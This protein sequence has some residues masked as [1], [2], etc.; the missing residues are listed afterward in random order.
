[1]PQPI[2]FDHI[3]DRY[4]ATRSDF[5]PF[6]NAIAEGLI[7]LSGMP[8]HGTLLEIAIGTGRI[9]LPLLAM[10]INVTGV[11]ISERMVERL[12]AKYAE[13]RAAE[14]ARDWGVLTTVI[15]DVTRLPCEP[16]T[17]DAALAVH[18]FHLVHDWRTALDEA[19]RMVRPGGAFL[20]GQDTRPANDVQWQM[21][22]RWM[23][24]VREIGYDV[25]LTYPG[26]G[27]S[28]VV[29][30]LRERGLDVVEEV[31]ATWET[32]QTP[33][34]MTKWITDRLW[35]RTWGVPD[36]VFAESVRRLTIWTQ[37]RFRAEMDVPVPTSASFK[38]ARARLYA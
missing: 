27:Y 25:N 29:V 5:G 17:F 10:G 32:E 20:L 19:L 1:M 12:R 15:A 3:A 7:R 18:I 36:D 9:S 26:A 16:A 38:V 23:D 30:D 14:P 34:Q 6:A 31:L 22:Q 21:Q 13:R 28:A 4:D 2:S 24:I 33:R 11:D 8:K 35:S 37:E